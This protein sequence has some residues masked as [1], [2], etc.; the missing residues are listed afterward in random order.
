MR[1]NLIT[2]IF[3]T[4]SLL[5]FANT[6]LS[7]NTSTKNDLNVSYADGIYTITTTGTDP[8]IATN[9][10][11]ATLGIAE[12]K[13][14]FQYQCSEDVSDV[15]LFFGSPET[16]ARSVHVSN[17]LKKT[18]SWTTATVNIAAQKKSFG[19]GNSGNYLRMDFGNKSG[20]TI[21][22]R[23]LGINGQHTISTTERNAEA[24]AI[25]RYLSTQY[26]SAVTNVEVTAD[27]I[28][29][30]G[31]TA[32]A[33]CK[34]IDVRVNG[35]ASRLSNYFTIATLPQGAFKVET[36]RYAVYDGVQ[37]D[38][39]L[40]KWAIIDASGSL[41]SHA[42]YAD[43]VA[44]IRQAEPGVLKSKKGLGG[45]FN[46]N[47]GDIQQ[48]GLHSVTLNVF[49]NEFMRMNRTKSDD[50]EYVYNGRTYYIDKER[51]QYYDNVIKTCEN[52]GVVIAAI[53]LA[54]PKEGEPEYAATMCHP[55]YGGTAPYTMP[56]VTDMDGINAYA[57]TIDYLANRYSVKGQGRIHHWIMHNEVDQNK[58]WTDMGEGQ[59][60]LRFMEHYERS[61]RL[62]SNIVRQY[63]PN[64]YVLGSYT[65]AW[66]STNGNGGYSPKQMMDLM[67]TF[68]NVEGDFR[69]GIADHPYP[70]SFF[71]PAF[72]S[73]DTD[74]T[75]TENA[76]FCTFKNVEVISDWILRPEHYYKG[77]E[78]RI[79]FFT[80][81]G[82]NSLQDTQ[83]QLNVQAAGAA[84]AWK[85]VQRSQ[86]IDA[87]MWHNW[88]DNPGEDGLHLGLRDSDLNPKPVW[89][90]WQAAG[91]DQESAVFDKYLSTIGISS[92]DQIHSG[93][94][95]VGNESQRFEP[96]LSTCNGLTGTK[97]NDY[98]SYTF[99]TT[100]TDPQ[101]QTEACSTALSPNSNVLSF[102][103]KL[104]KDVSDF[105]VFFSPMAEE[106]R[107]FMTALPATTEWRRVYIDIT[108]FRSV[109]GWGGAGSFLRF[110]PCRASGYTMQIRHICVNSGQIEDAALLG[111][112]SSGANNCSLNIDG[113]SGAAT[114]TTSGSDPYFYT[115]KLSTNLT[116][117][118]TKLIFDYQLS[119]ASTLQIYFLD[120]AGEV[121]ST[122]VS[123]P[124][125]STWTRK[126]IDIASI[127]R[128]HGWG[129]EGDYLRIDPAS[130][131]GITFKIRNLSVNTGEYTSD[132]NLLLDN[133]NTNWL[134]LSR[135]ANPT[136]WDAD[137]DYGSVPAY[138][139]WTLCTTGTDPYLN[140]TRLDK[141][142]NADATK[143]YFEYKATADVSPF[144]IYLPDPE[145][146]QRSQR[147]YGI[148][149]ATSEWTPVTIDLTNLRNTY[150]W[151][152][153]GNRLRLDFGSAKGNTINVRYLTIYND[154]EPVSSVDTLHRSGAT[155][156]GTVGGAWIRTDSRCSVTFFNITGSAVRTVEAD[157]NT[158]V[159]L[160]RGIYIVDGR[161]VVVR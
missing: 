139:N 3:C 74:A 106:V 68:S 113:Q 84:W 29:I 105:Q 136:P 16:E 35:S 49:F 135:S 144:E 1:R 10:L 15:Q 94:S 41:N 32:S 57:A 80:E 82:V 91:T 145:T 98:Q 138:Y 130:S 151:G 161:K 131:S 77:K 120:Y 8:H 158:F 61:M 56:N 124:A 146:A 72:W 110:D 5:A 23:Y 46:V 33:G 153:A 37:Y 53:L 102:E 20:V 7:F 54:N 12:A 76:G 39:L 89:Y 90:V 152:L 97:N 27:K 9:T 93:V 86:G 2:L 141:N 95:V 114:A 118:A 155:V 13:L 69:W 11:S 129:F 143:L 55:E 81:N 117:S 6:G 127:R 111:I 150:G 92:W 65:S 157:G 28:I 71:K 79:L 50:V 64:A 103:Y 116:E 38:R 122:K 19:W 67:V 73:A 85:K 4:V 87:V 42:H 47:L 96:N 134:S 48:L 66:T 88:F 14:A 101:F 148:M 147:F 78:K 142:L 149:P 115:T 21:K 121:R 132:H 62:V 44:S 119:T 104:D 75:Y 154:D 43:H 59:P 25:A 108:N 60:L 160:A 156:I 40:S 58:Y 99:K 22:I 63:D 140:T 126:T 123:L 24:N 52:N 70:Q 125:A 128:D 51:Q 17:L 100:G 31:T 26:P 133:A 45:I 83:A 137:V 30:E 34:L 109:Y 18:S 159:S 36:A 107:S 112:S